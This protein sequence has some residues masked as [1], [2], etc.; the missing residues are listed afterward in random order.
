MTRLLSVVTGLMITLVMPVTGLSKPSAQTLSVGMS[1]AFKPYNYIEDNEFKGIDIDLSKYIF[2]QLNYNLEF[3]TF[4]IGRIKILA[5]KG[6]IDIVLSTYCDDAYSEN[7]INTSVPLYHVNI[8]AFENE[9]L[10]QKVLVIE[11]LKHTNVGVVRGNYFNNSLESTRNIYSQ[12]TLSTP[13]LVQQLDKKRIDVA[14]DEEF[15]FLMYANSLGVNVRPSL[16]LHKTG[17]CIG[18]S[19]TSLEDKAATLKRDIDNLILTLKRTGEL[20]KMLASLRQ[21]YIDK[22]TE[23]SSH[24]ND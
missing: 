9:D 1:H 11:D 23:H 4:P 17:V 5:D 14:I 2:R 8:I 6:A 7:V 12:K 22:K 10:P 21:Q 19:A 15:P 18:L 3:L 13:S 20:D 16:K 24:L